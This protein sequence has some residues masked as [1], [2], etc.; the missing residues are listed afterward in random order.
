VSQTLGLRLGTESEIRLSSLHR[1]TDA[2]A[3]KH[4]TWLYSIEET[5]DRNGRLAAEQQHDD[6]DEEHEAQ[7]AAA[8]PD[9]VGENGSSHWSV[10]ARNGR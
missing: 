2:D 10:P 3:S 9:I 6:H 7:G 1:R 5:T 4:L 8:D